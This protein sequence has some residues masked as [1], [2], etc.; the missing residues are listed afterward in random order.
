MLWIDSKAASGATQAK[1]RAHRGR[2][3]AANCG[4]F[5]RPPTVEVI[6]PISGND[7]SVHNPIDQVGDKHVV[8]AHAHKVAA[9]PQARETIEV[10]VQLLH[11]VKARFLINRVTASRI[12]S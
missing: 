12:L 3:A 2:F 11:F 9:Q 10:N 8:T 4:A 7:P 1:F 5:L 6:S